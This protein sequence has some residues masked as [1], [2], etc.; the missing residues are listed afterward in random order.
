MKRTI[1]ILA[2]LVISLGVMAQLS[3][4]DKAPGFNLKNVDGEM[5]S[6]D[7]ASGDEGAIV[8]FTC[9]GCPVAKAYEQ[10][11]IDLDNKYR[12]KG[13][14]VIAIQPNDPSI[15]PVDSY[16]NMQKRAKEKGYPFPYL[17]DEKQEVFPAYGATKTPHTYLL[18]KEGEN[19][20]VGYIGAIDDNQRS[21]EVE[22]NFL[23]NAIEALSKGKTPKPAETRAVGCSIKVKK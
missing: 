6:L 14:P 21:A 19:F 18:Q 8:V 5:L 7:Q 9:N 4:G 23:E 13:W 10:R 2:A 3:P 11:I 12:D 17:F 1:L 22:E 15:T 16:E 20:K